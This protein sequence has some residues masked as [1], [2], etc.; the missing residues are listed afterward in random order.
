MNIDAIHRESFGSLEPIKPLEWGILCNNKVHNKE[1]V[2]RI[3][4]NPNEIE[5]LYRRGWRVHPG[6]SK[7]LLRAPETTLCDLSNPLKNYVTN[8]RALLSYY[9]Y[10]DRS[11]IDILINHILSKSDKDVQAVETAGD[12]VE[13]EK[14]IIGSSEQIQW[15]ATQLWEQYLDQTATSVSSVTTATEFEST[16]NNWSVL[17]AAP[18]TQRQ[19]RRISE[20]YETICDTD[21]PDQLMT[22]YWDDVPDNDV[23]VFIAKAAIQYFLGFRETHPNR[24]AIVWEHHASS[25]GTKDVK[26]FDTPIANKSVA[27]IDKCY[28]GRTIT[29]LGEKI[30]SQGGETDLIGMF[31]KSMEGVNR[32]DH[33]FFIDQFYDTDDIDMNAEWHLEL[34]TDRF[35]LN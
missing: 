33:I 14:R 19:Y 3:T 18:Q 22:G 32:M 16:I 27:V 12:S 10:L 9:R 8:P 29:S 31:P 34:F 26:I 2:V 25:V 21:I 15:I 4:T 17:N 24:E 30:E 23:Y 20:F 7:Y 1:N 6:E 11:D 5:D 28:T 35:E 13:A